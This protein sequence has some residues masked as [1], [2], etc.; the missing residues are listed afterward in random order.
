V[1]FQDESIA[2][3]QKY[4]RLIRQKQEKQKDTKA[5]EPALLPIYEYEEIQVFH[6]SISLSLPK[7]FFDENLAIENKYLWSKNKEMAMVLSK[8][9]LE[10]EEIQIEQL[11]NTMET[12]LKKN[13]IYVEFEEFQEVQEECFRK[14]TVACRMP[15]T[16][17]YMYQT[18]LYLIGH[19]DWVSLI[20]T[21]IE[22]KKYLYSEMIAYIQQHIKVEFANES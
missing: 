4:T 1:V 8:Q 21:C 18:Q 7:Q 10:G 17:G 15:T 13:E 2:K 11:K 20:I 12:E 3:I 6:H 14:I 16:A 5:S 22:K 19:K 9:A